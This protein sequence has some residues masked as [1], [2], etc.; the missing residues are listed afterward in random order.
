MQ[1]S[2]F[3]IAEMCFKEE[4]KQDKTPVV[5]LWRAQTMCLFIFI[6]MPHAML[7]LNW[8]AH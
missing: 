4:T 8:Y 1:I 6:Y 5:G 7:G 3:K 2:S